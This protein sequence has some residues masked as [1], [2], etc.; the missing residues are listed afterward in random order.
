MVRQAAPH[1]RAS[2]CITTGTLAQPRVTEPLIFFPIGPP[3]FTTKDMGAT[4]SSVRVPWYTPSGRSSAP[5]EA[6]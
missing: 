1:S 5:A 6:V 3:Q 4:L 2:S